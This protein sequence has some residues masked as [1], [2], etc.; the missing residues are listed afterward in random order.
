[1]ICIPVDVYT[2]LGQ[3]RGW[4]AQPCW[5]HF[6]GY[7]VLL[8]GGQRA[9]VGGDVRFGGLL[10]LCSISST[11]EREGMILRLAVVHRERMA[12]QRS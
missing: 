6:D 12:I 4:G 10:D 8:K 11:D 9:L 2:Y 1:M 7:Q 5:T 3:R